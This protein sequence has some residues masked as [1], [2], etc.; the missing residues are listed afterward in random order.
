MKPIRPSSA[1]HKSQT[2]R[3]SSDNFIPFHQ[4]L[5]KLAKPIKLSRP[6]TAVLPQFKP[7]AKTLNPCL[8]DSK[9]LI[10]DKEINEKLQEC[11]KADVF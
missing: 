11:L 2:L 10:S 5:L 7:S 6:Q 1:I 3:T 8:K 4:G 9:P